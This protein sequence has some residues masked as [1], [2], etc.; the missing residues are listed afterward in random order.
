MKVSEF[1]FELPEEVIALRPCVPR[2]SAKMLVVR[3]DGI[4]DQSVLD[5]AAHL[6]E[7]DILV[8]N[9]TKVLPVRLSGRIGEG[10]VEATLLKPLGD[11]KWSALCKPGKRFR[12]GTKVDLD[13][14]IAEVISKDISGE[15]ILQFH[16]KNLLKALENKGKMPLPPYIAKK[17][18]VDSRD[19]DDYQTLYARKVGAIAAPTAGLHFT[20]R[21]LE[22][23]KLKGIQTAFLTL[24]VGAG[25]F[26]PVK[27]DDTE[28][29]KMHAEW[30]E[31]SKEVA[32][33]I[34]TARKKGGRV[35][36]V[37]TTSLRLLESAADENGDVHP[38][39][40]ET[41]IFITPGYSFK[42]VDVLMTNFH[43]PA[44]TL[45]MLVSAFLGLDQM[46]AAYKHAIQN[47]YRFYSYGDS[48]LLFPKK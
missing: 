14:L 10:Q 7:K 45:F 9:D 47:D 13:G 48:C 1:D 24:H 11:N 22:T 4:E 34:N 37:G 21:M 36:A 27:V 12:P 28:N 42:V 26:L 17:R 31:I 44:S 3:P 16:A 46:K 29:H 15:I 33:Q 23:L 43:L 39:K 19:F 40:A 41:D 8:F 5:L 38:F 20:D 6:N 30:G 35:I 2:D 32:E 18:A 25:T